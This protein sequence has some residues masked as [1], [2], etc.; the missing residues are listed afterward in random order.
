M[1][2]R[3]VRDDPWMA[4]L[5][6]DT[7]E[8][9]PDATEARRARLYL[10]KRLDHE[11]N[12]PVRADRVARLKAMQ[13]HAAERVASTSE[14]PR[15]ND[16][17][18]SALPG[19]G[20][21]NRRTQGAEA[22]GSV[23]DRLTRWLFPDGSASVGRWAAVA[24]GLAAVVLLPRVMGPMLPGDEPEMKRIPN[25]QGIGIGSSSAIQVENS[26][27]AQLGQQVMASLI[28]LGIRPELREQ[29]GAVVVLATIPADQ[30]VPAQKA[31]AALGI[32]WSGGPMLEITI[33]PTA[34]P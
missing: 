34:R 27:P 30:L 21:T 6:G 33:R 1:T 17:P 3:D 7:A 25:E 22:T 31:L 13:A 4:A 12:R 18:V 11:L 24:C 32:G 23:L 15:A 28:D 16:P 10:E 9:S 8:D 20:A 29:D 19:P 2:D 14:I 5:A 26:Q